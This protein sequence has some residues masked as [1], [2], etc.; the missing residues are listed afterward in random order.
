M[1]NASNLKSELIVVG[2]D[3]GYVVDEVDPRGGDSWFPE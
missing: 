1:E 3:I 2:P